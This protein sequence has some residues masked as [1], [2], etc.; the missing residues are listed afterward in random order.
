MGST[1]VAFRLTS[2]RAGV[3]VTLALAA[4]AAAY[5]L[6]TPGG[7]HRVVLLAIPVLAAL[8][9]VVISRLPADLIARTERHY[10]RLIVGWNLSHSVA[11]ALACTLDGGIHS[12]LAAIFFISV[13]FA[14]ASLPPR[15]VAVGALGLRRDRSR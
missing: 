1:E 7:P 13:A 12:P 8:D 10:V 3:R 2:I 14:A 11:V 6:A 15:P 5:L 9:A 4:A